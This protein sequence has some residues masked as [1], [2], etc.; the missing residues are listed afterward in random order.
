MLQEFFTEHDAQFF[1]MYA[2]SKNPN[3]YYATKFRVPDPVFY[4]IGDDGTELLVVPEMERR[5]AERESRVREIA[6]LNDLGFHERLKEL[7]DAKK[8][9]AETYADLIMT[10]HGKRVLVPD[11]FPAFL[12]Q[13]FAEKFDVHIVENPYSIMRAVKTPE[14]IRN[15]KETSDATIQAFRFFL[16]IL[17]KERNSERLRNRVESFLYSRGFMAEDTIISGDSESSDPH[18]TGHGDIEFHV[19][20]DVFPRD[21]KTGYHSDFTRTVMI[22]ENH[23][24]EEM[25]DACVEAKNRAI[26]MIKDGVSGEEVHFLVCDVLESHGYTTLRQKAKEGFIHSTGHGV[27]LEVHERPRIYERGEE[28]KTGM[29]ITLEPGLY[30][31]GVGGVRVEDTVVV[32]KSGCEV[33]TQFEDIVRL[34]K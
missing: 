34:V 15:I 1:I 20:F 18:C 16:E 2:S 9:L 27:G 31:E 8:A 24:I 10:H 22:Q 23:E 19:I 12:Y 14:E 17:R 28:L 33:L 5:R 7:G 25:L 30:Y 11:D 32:R 13:T 3:L 26:E 21:R 4:M 29:V 6:S